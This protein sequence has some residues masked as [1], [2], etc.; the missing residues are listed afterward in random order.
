MCLCI[1]RFTSQRGSSSAST[2]IPRAG[3]DNI[4]VSDVLR[5]L[6]FHNRPRSPVNRICSPSSILDSASA[7]GIF[8]ISPVTTA[9]GANPVTRGTCLPVPI[10]RPLRRTLI[11]KLQ[12][13]LF[14]SFFFSFFFSFF[15]FLV[16]RKR[17]VIYIYIRLLLSFYY[18]YSK[19][20]G[21]FCMGLD[22]AQTIFNINNTKVILDHQLELCSTTDGSNREKGRRCH[23]RPGRAL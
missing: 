12:L 1:I 5:N 8:T 15:S 20:N 21:Q 11:L 19:G 23:G 22:M 3:D 13:F 10:P 14:L 9:V 4:S 7:S 6:P 16:V 17:R 18:I 2:L